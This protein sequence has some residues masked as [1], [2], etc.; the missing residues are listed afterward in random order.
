MCE[1]IWTLPFCN[2]SV[3]AALSRYLRGHCFELGFFPRLCWP[4]QFRPFDHFCN[5]RVHGSNRSQDVWRQ[6]LACDP[7]GWLFHSCTCCADCRSPR[8]AA[9]R[10]LCGFGPLCIQPVGLAAYQES[11]PDHRWV[12]RTA[13]SQISRKAELNSSEDTIIQREQQTAQSRHLAYRT[14]SSGSS[15]PLRCLRARLPSN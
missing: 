2:G 10:Y 7:H 15:E 11:K 13:L 5:G 9:E 14:V 12:R 8:C 3:R 6:S 4:V 1:C